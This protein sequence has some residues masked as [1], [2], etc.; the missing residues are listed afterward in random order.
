MT[1]N[2][3]P[4]K[5]Q[6]DAMLCILGCGSVS[7]SIDHPLVDERGMVR[8]Y[9]ESNGWEVRFS[10]SATATQISISRI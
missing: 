6:L 7:V 9:Y 8:D 4:F 3:I 5:E 2:V 1:R 10:Y